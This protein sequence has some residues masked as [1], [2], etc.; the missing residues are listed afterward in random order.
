MGSRALVEILHSKG[1]RTTFSGYT[2]TKRGEIRVMEE[3]PIDINTFIGKLQVTYQKV[4]A[5]LS[6]GFCFLCEEE[7]RSL[8]K[9]EERR[10]EV[11][12]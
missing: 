8:V 12:R 2:V 6:D 7:M 5:F 4:C 11:L 9:H 10:E 3:M 1:N